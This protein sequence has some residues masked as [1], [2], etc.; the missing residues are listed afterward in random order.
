MQIN[1]VDG[2]EIRLFGEQGTVAQLDL[3][4]TVVALYDPKTSQAG[5]VEVVV[6]SLA[7]DLVTACC[8]R[9]AWGS[10][11]AL[12]GRSAFP[13][14]VVVV[15]LSSG[16]EFSLTVSPRTRV[17]VG[18]RAAQ[19]GDLV[20]RVPVKVRFDVATREAWPSTPSTPRGLS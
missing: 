6:P 20:R 12:S 2:T 16:C 8:P 10:W 18:E 9:S 3:G 7:S 14:L 13:T 4:H 19:P 5:S 11:R 17:Q 15:E 1:I